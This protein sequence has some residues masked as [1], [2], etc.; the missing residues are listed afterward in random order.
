[1]D[2]LTDREKEIFKTAIE[3]DQRWLIEHAAHRQE[4]ICQAQSLN[5][6]F[7]A[8]ERILYLHNVHFMAW[9]QGVK[10][11][12]YLRS[13]AVKRADSVSAKVSDEALRDTDNTC[14]SCEG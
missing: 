8:T 3:L 11:L 13:E 14:L 5:L 2:I 9:K 4:Y 7:G 10:T 12:Y 6:F 1:L